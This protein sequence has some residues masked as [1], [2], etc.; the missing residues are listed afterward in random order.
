MRANQRAVLKVVVLV[1]TAIL[2][3]LLAIGPG[4]LV[5]YSPATRVGVN[6]LLAYWIAIPLVIA[7]ITFRSSQLRAHLVTAAAFAFP[8]IMHIGKAAYNLLL[9]DIPEIQHTPINTAAD[10]TELLLLSFLL[11]C[12]VLCYSRSVLLDSPKQRVAFASLILLLPLAIRGLLWFL[13]FPNLSS[14]G[15]KTLSWSLVIVGALALTS[16]LAVLPRVKSKEL[17]LDKGYFASAILLLVIAIIA[18]GFHASTGRPGW[19]F[20]ETMQM[21]GFLVLSLATGIPYMRR[22]GYGR[23][24]AY[25][26]VLGMI[27][28]FYLPLVITI[29]IESSGLSLLPPVANFLAYAIIH[30][31]AG[32][33]SAMMA[34]LLY[35]YSRH[36]FS[37]THYPLMLIFGLWAS[38]TVALLVAFTLPSFSVLGEPSGIYIV[39][40]I[41]TLALLITAARY[42]VDPPKRKP[43]VSRLVAALIVSVALTLLGETVNQVFLLVNPSFIG[44]LLGEAVEL[45]ASLAVM[46]AFTYLIF[47]LARGSH[48]EMSASLYVTLLLA[49]W[50]LPSVLKSYYSVWTLGWF[51]SEIL[52]LMGIVAGPPILAWLYI[53]ALEESKEMHTRSSLFADLLMH[54]VTNYNQVLMTSLELLGSEGVHTEQRKRLASDGKQIISFAEQLIQNVRLLTET[55]RLKEKPLEPTNLVSAFVAA[56]DHFSQKVGSDAVVVE[57]DPE[58]AEAAVLA[59]QLIVHVFLNILYYAL[60]RSRHGVT[61]KSTIRLTEELGDDYWEVRISAPGVVADMKANPMESQLRSGGSL[62]LVAAQKM[63]EVFRGTLNVIDDSGESDNGVIYVIRLPAIKD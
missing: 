24:P 19:E 30:V 49:I 21:G 58:E 16:T 32:S 54:D 18:L 52:L 33:L 63:L 62:G 36:K 43:K 29:A 37:W 46:L 56:L 51:V 48:G 10:T 9:L 3:A 31:G 55:M 26:L 47:L 60:E 41:V 6:S 8:V 59:N 45:V 11:L 42:E 44:S 20:A 17:P 1:P 12:V 35:L 61:I 39:G 23:R 25:G 34:V 5:S 2:G 14:L 57:F 4:G 38:L 53:K 40:A 50:I 28:L 7:V 13:V 27:L 15:L 22:A